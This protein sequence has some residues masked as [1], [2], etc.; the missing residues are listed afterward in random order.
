MEEEK[1]MKK[2][3][4]TKKKAQQITDLKQKND[5]KYQKQM[6]E[7]MNNQGNLKSNQSTNYEKRHKLTL[8]IKQK[9]F[10][11][12]EAK[13]AEAEALKNHIRHQQ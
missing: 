13:K 6:M 2:I 5:D 11:L 8:E 12:Q 9:Q 4:E 3:N 1:A 10:Q 7:E